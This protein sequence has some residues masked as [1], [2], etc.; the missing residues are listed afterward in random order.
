M[1]LEQL[2]VQLRLL[3]NDPTTSEEE[4]NHI[5]A[6][7]REAMGADDEEDVLPYAA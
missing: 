3:L 1:T 4:L 7:L 5:V 6:Q 2:R